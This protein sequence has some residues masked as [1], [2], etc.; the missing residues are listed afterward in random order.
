MFAA[1]VQYQFLLRAGTHPP[2][3]LIF[4]WQQAQAH[5][6]TIL[7]GSKKQKQQKNTRPV[8]N[9]PPFLR[10]KQQKDTHPLTSTPS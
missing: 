5:S 7:T 2:C 10:K 9:A 6:T 1:A 8:I 3:D 4:D